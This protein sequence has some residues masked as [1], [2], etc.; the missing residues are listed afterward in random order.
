M[1]CSK[2]PGNTEVVFTNGYRKGDFK[3]QVKDLRC[4]HGKEKGETGITTEEASLQHLMTVS[5]ITVGTICRTNCHTSLLSA[6]RLFSKL[7]KVVEV[8]S[9]D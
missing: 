6:W 5:S 8:E 2:F 3:E 4:V 7:L 9:L 1:A